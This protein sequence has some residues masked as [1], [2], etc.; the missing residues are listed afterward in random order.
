MQQT[1][2]RN[3]VQNRENLKSHIEEETLPSNILMMSS[4]ILDELVDLIH[5]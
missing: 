1:W 4:H 2:R 5:R 3:D